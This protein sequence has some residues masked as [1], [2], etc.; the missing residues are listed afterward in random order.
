[1]KIELTQQGLKELQGFIITARYY[2]YERF[3][4]NQ[5]TPNDYGYKESYEIADKWLEMIETLK[6]IQ[7]KEDSE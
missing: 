3:K 7:D 1:M 5:N 4:L 2:Y 6:K